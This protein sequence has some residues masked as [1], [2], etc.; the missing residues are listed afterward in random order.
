M[1]EHFISSFRMY[2]RTSSMVGLAYP[3]EVIVTFKV[4]KSLFFV[5]FECIS[6]YF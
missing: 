6:T 2:R 4:K 5:E 3:A 1:A